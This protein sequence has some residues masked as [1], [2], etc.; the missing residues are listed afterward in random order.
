[1]QNG[2]RLL[3]SPLEARIGRGVYN[4]SLSPWMVVVGNGL[5]DISM[6]F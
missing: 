4:L 1:M 3:S 6:V 2:P 5:G